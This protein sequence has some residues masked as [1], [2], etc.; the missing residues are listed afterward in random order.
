MVSATSSAQVDISANVVVDL[1]LAQHAVV[2]EHGLPQIGTIVG[3]YHHLH[4]PL[5][6]SVQSLCKSYSMVG[7][8]AR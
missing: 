6:Y 2:L 7:F 4:S 1:G 8:H 5:P 3:H